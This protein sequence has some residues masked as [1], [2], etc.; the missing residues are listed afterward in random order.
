MRKKIALI[1]IGVLIALMITLF[2]HSVIVNGGVTSTAALRLT[3]SLAITISS[4][5]KI[6]T[7]TGGMSLARRTVEKQYAD[8]IGKAFA[9][10]DRKRLRKKL[11]EAIYIFSTNSKGALLRFEKLQKKCATADDYSTVLTFIGL[12][13]TNI[14]NIDMAIAAYREADKYAQQTERHKLRSTILSNLGL[15][16]ANKGENGKAMSCYDQA[17]ECDKQNAYAYGNS[18]S[19][20]F[21][22]GDYGNA[23]PRCEKALEIKSNEY[24]F[25]ATLCLCYCALQKRQ[26]AE[27]YYNIAVNNGQNAD[28]LKNAMERYKNID[29]TLPDVPQ[30]P[31]ES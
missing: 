31:A 26:E 25:A 16:Y 22:S 4:I 10:P 2:I 5:V 15:I 19:L 18:A 12:T 8:I 17:I 29:I 20:Y 30:S 1:L 21:R 27:K 3:L 14:G 28:Q 6:V 11:T 9:E 24:H 7:G 13:N 23:I